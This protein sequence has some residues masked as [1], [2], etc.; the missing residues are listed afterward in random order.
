M[1]Y[2]IV[3]GHGDYVCCGSYVYQGQ[4]YKVIGKLA[5]AR[6]FKTYQSAQNALSKMLEHG[7]ANIDVTYHVVKCKKGDK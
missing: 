1:E 5:D 6:S 3:S 4:S 2:Y 7:Y